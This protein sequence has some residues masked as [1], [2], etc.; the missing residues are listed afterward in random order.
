MEMTWNNNLNECPI[1]KLVNVGYWSG[2]IWME[3]VAS[4]RRDGWV[5]STGQAIA[6]PDYWKFFNPPGE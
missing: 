4:K 1:A 2:A 3:H 5:T 6:E